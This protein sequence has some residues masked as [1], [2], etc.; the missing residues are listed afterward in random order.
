MQGCCV[1]FYFTP[2]CIVLIVFFL[3]L[4]PSTDHRDIQSFQTI[5]CFIRDLWN[6]NS[7][8][9]NVDIY[10]QSWIDISSGNLDFQDDASQT[11]GVRIICRSGTNSCWQSFT[12]AC[13][14][15]RNNLK[16]LGVAQCKT[17]K[18]RNMKRITA[19]THFFSISTCKNIKSNWK[20]FDNNRYKITRMTIALFW[21]AIEVQASGCPPSS[22][23]P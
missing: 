6:S 2:L 4:I 12:F 20:T 22:F 23:T 18:V 5:M 13:F 3:V 17:L 10:W 8:R 7:I 16:R 1:R 9:R 19:H 11:S 14:I 21:Q 15:R